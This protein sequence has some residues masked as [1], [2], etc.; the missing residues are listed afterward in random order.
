M[1]RNLRDTGGYLIMPRER[2]VRTVFLKLAGADTVPFV[3][4][5]APVDVTYALNTATQTQLGVSLVANVLDAGKTEAGSPYLA[6]GA[7]YEW[8]F[9]DRADRAVGGSVKLPITGGRVL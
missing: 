9:S 6:R 5:H 7:C 3:N 8:S 1:L 2:A 4:G